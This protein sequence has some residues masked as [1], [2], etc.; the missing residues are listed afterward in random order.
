MKSSR[1][2]GLIWGGVGALALG[3]G[4]SPGG[5]PEQTAQTDTAEDS[6]S[7][8][9]PAGGQVQVYQANF[10]GGAGSIDR[11]NAFFHSFGTN[12]RSCNS[13]HKL[14]N[15]LGISADN[16]RRI[17]DQT[18][19]LDPIF[20]TNDGSNAPTGAFANTSTVAARRRSFSMLLDHGVIRIG[21][22]MPARA[23]FRLSAVRDPYSFASQDELSLFRRPLP[24]A[25]VAFNTLSLWDGRESEGRAA[26]R[27]ALRLAEQARNR[28]KA[29]KIRNR[30]TQEVMFTITISGGVTALRSGD[31][32]AAFIE[33]A[34]EALYRSKQAGR[35][36]VSEA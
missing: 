11:N 32:A 9:N 15:A 21:L 12:G 5:E 22:G 17:F 20:R 34:D 3:L 25:N 1:Y 29:M 28:A 4:C 27:D 36:R 14:E 30:N 24:A 18:Q 8:R 19:G 35:D 6:L 33:R 23:D 31:D 13:C 16:I 7:I 10:R 2:R 26:N